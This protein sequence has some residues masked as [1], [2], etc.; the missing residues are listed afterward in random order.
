M[1]R[2]RR[3]RKAA[4]AACQVAGC[5][6]GALSVHGRACSGSKRAWI[7]AGR[8]REAHGRKRAPA[9][10]G[11]HA[12]WGAA[13]AP[14]NRRPRAPQP[15][16]R[17]QDTIVRWRRMSGYNTLWV[18]G[19]GERA[20]PLPARPPAW[21]PARLP[22]G[23]CGAAPAVLVRLQAPRIACPALHPSLSALPPRDPPSPPADHAG[24]A[25]QTVVEKKIARERGL[26]RHD[27]GAPPRGGAGAGGHCAPGPGALRPQSSRAA[28]KRGTGRLPARTPCTRPHVSSPTRRHAFAPQAARASW[29]RCGSGWASTETASATS[30]AAWAPRW[31][32]TARWAGG[33]P[34]AHE[35][36][37]GGRGGSDC[38]SGGC[39]L[40]PSLGWDRSVGWARREPAAAGCVG[41]I[42]RQQRPGQRSA[43][44]R[45]PSRCPRPKPTQLSSTRTHR[46]PSPWTRT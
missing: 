7:A 28:W 19:T 17:A 2:L 6:A 23:R 12:A 41:G 46:R 44:L 15:P 40:G 35:G 16:F 32:G 5:G 10:G 39:C 3:L 22:A 33:R 9:A 18:P 4:E 25:T 20:P 24:I 21:Q 30:C 34:G 38:S 37:V 45:P 29:P 14:R 26:T 36:R 31:T 8:E 42:A 43:A 13:A 11:V 1:R 27:L